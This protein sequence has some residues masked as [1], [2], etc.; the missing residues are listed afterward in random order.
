[1]RI[2]QILSILTSI[3]LSQNIYVNAML[4]D[5]GG[6]EITGNFVMNHYDGFMNALESSKLFKN[7]VIL[8]RENSLGNKVLEKGS[9]YLDVRSSLPCHFSYS[10]VYCVEDWNWYDLPNYK[11]GGLY[12]GTNSM[13]NSFSNFDSTEFENYIEGLENWFDQ[14][15]EDGI[16]NYDGEN[17]AEP[18]NDTSD[19]TQNVY[20]N[21]M[22][23]NTSM[24]GSNADLNNRENLIKALDSSKIKDQYIIIDRD[25]PKMNLEKG[26]IFIVLES[27]YEKFILFSTVY[28]AE[29]WNW[30][31][32][33][34]KYNSGGVFIANNSLAVG[35][36]KVQFGSVIKQIE[37][38]LDKLEKDGIFNYKE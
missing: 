29:D 36:G 30:W 15:E 24:H 33:N 34:E 8:T 9:F 19:Q 4:I 17:K 2:F 10:V 23:F 1:M 26:S 27:F 31:N 38:L 21:L 22:S 37:W 3:T 25:N 35:N 32:G 11:S 12:L 18:I 28:V 13:S 5:T 20:I 6:G 14:F 16:F 7:C